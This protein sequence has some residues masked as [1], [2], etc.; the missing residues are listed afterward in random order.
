MGKLE[1]LLDSINE[2]GA[3]IVGGAPFLRDAI[4][5]FDAAPRYMASDD[6]ND[7][8][9]GLAL[10]AQAEREALAAQ[11]KADMPSM[12]KA[13]RFAGAAIDT[14][15]MGPIFKMLF[16]GGNGVLAGAKHLYGATPTPVKVGI[17]GGLSSLLFD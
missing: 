6:P 10:K 14:L 1:E 7:T 8:L 3:S 5:Y 9:R 11:H 16:G 13:G 12:A 17:G 15:A 2:T 4:D